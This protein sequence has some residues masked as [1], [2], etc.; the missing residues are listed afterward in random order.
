MRSAMSL[1][2]LVALTRPASPCSCAT[3]PLGDAMKNAKHVFVGRIIGETKTKVETK[4]CRRNA[5]WCRYTYAYQVAVEGHWKG[6]IVAELTIDTG[7]GAGD[8]SMGRLRGTKYI[9]FASGDAARPFVH[10]CGGTRAATDATLR[11]MASAFGAPK[12]P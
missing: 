10:V 12:V 2:F 7:S 11:Q 9:F 4:E 8:C 1:L 5:D 3:Q 6:D